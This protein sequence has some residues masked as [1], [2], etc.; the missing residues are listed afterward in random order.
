MLKDGCRTDNT[1]ACYMGTL[2]R[3]RCG[4]REEVTLREL[5]ETCPVLK[6]SRLTRVAS[7]VSISKTKGMASD[8]T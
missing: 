2:S 1:V 4:P 3:S 5:R 6:T 7:T 8:G